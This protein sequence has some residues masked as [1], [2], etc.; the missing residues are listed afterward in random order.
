MDY[1][2]DSEKAVAEAFRKDETLLKKNHYEVQID[3]V[4]PGY[5]RVQV[6][7]EAHV[8]KIEW[9]HDSQWRFFPVVEHPD[10][11]YQLHDVDL[12]INKVLALA[13]RNEARDFLDVAY[14][15]ENILSLGA[16][17]WAATG[18]DP[19][20]TPQ[21]LLELLKRRRHFHDE[22]FQ[23]LNLA[24]KIDLHDLKKNW[25]LMIEQAGNFIQSRSLSEQGCL[26]L[27]KKDLKCYTP[28]SKDKIDQDYVVHYGK[29]GGVIPIFR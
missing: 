1:F 13:G 5:V 8:T 21:S 15:H 14:I 3:I 7:K 27:R 10:S 6:Q 22:D 24:K 25:L 23:R 19:G 12:A 28:D 16:M 11:G 4:Q 9:A 2:H 18:K 29:P 26:Y 20:F 17:C